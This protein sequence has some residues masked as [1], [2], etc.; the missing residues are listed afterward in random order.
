MQIQVAVLVCRDAQFDHA[1]NFRGSVLYLA[2][3]VTL[4][5]PVGEVRQLA[6]DH[7]MSVIQHGVEPAP[8]REESL[9]KT[10]KVRNVFKSRCNGQSD[11]F[12]LLYCDAHPNVMIIRKVQM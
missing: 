1:T 7:Q 6:V 11:R 5:L 10:A 2:E 9:A 12:L 4:F 8:C 3:E